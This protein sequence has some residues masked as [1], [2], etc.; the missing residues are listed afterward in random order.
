ME[1]RKLAET[2]LLQV[3]CLWLLQEIDERWSRK[4]RNIQPVLA[5]IYENRRVRFGDLYP[6]ARLMTGLSMV[7]VPISFT[8]NSTSEE[9]QLID[10]GLGCDRYN[11]TYSEAGSACAVD[12]ERLLKVVRDATAHLPDFMSGKVVPNISFDEGILCCKSRVRKAKLVFESEQGY[13]AFL[14]DLLRVVRRT[15]G[16]VLATQS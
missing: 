12:A 9:T 15:A 4:D 3:E 6:L 14:G 7:L 11:I 5:E 13:I 2:V 16:R 10:Q 8:L 1:L